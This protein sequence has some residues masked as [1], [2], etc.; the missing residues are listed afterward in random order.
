[1]A[2]SRIAAARPPI[3]APITTTRFFGPADSAARAPTFL[4]R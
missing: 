2:A 3:P 4:Y 1:V